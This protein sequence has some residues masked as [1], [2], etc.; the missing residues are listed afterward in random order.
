[1]I[2][3]ICEV[4]RLG[5]NQSV[6]FEIPGQNF[7]RDAFLIKTNGECKAY[8]NECPHIG[9]ALDWD[10]NEFFSTDFAMLV[11]KNHGATFSPENGDCLSGPCQG[12]GL[13]TIPIKQLDGWYVMDA[14]L[15]G[16]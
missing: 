1:M 12:I 16:V 10:D 8:Y 3:K 11:C 2:I 6:K 13:K 5:E 7:S 15:T 14:S 9:L 4:E